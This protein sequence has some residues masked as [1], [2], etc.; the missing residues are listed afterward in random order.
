MA[1]KQT[2]PSAGTIRNV[3]GQDYVSTGSEFIPM[4]TS[5][6]EAPVATPE[7]TM[8]APIVPERS[9]R[10][11]LSSGVDTV[12]EFLPAA[13]AALGSIAGTPGTLLGYAGGQG[14]RELVQRGSEI[15]G[16]VRDIYRNLRDG[17][18]NVRLA[19]LRGAS[20]GVA[21]GTNIIPGGRGARAAVSSLREGNP[22]TAT[23]Q[24]LGAGLDV[25]SVGASGPIRT[26]FANAPGRSTMAALLGLGGAKAGEAV[27]DFAADEMKLTPDQ[28]VLAETLG[29]IPGFAV[30][31]GLVHPKTIALAKDVAASPITQ[32][33]VSGG[34]ALAAGG[35]IPGAIAAAL[36]SSAANKGFKAA[37]DYA[38]VRREKIA[39][40]E[41]MQGIGIAAKREDVANKLASDATL[42]AEARAETAKNT[43]AKTQSDLFKLEQ[44]HKNRL[45][46]EVSQAGTSAEGAAL[47]RSQQVG[48]RFESREYAAKLAKEKA[49]ANAL[50][51][52]RQDALRASREGKT[53]QNRKEG[54]ARADEI[55]AQQERLASEKA[56]TTRGNVL[57][58][59]AAR[60]ARK[61]EITAD[62]AAAQLSKT[63]LSNVE[64]MLKA[65][66]P[67][68]L[69]ATKQVADYHLE[70]A[71][72]M[73]PNFRAALQSKI[74][75]VFETQSA[76][77]AERRAAQDAQMQGLE[78]NDIR[79]T[80][81]SSTVDAN[82]RRQ[83]ITE[84]F[85]KP[86]PVEELIPQQNTPTPGAMSAPTGAAPK[87]S[88][89]VTSDN[90]L[91]KLKEQAD[92]EPVL[93]SLEDSG[94][95]PMAARARELSRKL[96]LSESE[97]TEL[98]GLL[99]RMKLSAR[100]AGVTYPGAGGPANIVN[101][102]V[103]GQTKLNTAG[104]N[105]RR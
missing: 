35:G 96:V 22:Y 100:E 72:G 62:H 36:T 40:D 99:D 75:Q 102:P 38:A 15:P 70:L 43:S 33:L 51:L 39:S 80:R 93:V 103:T 8:D 26:M 81:S 13:G 101:N 97:A 50:E 105:K 7:Q 56:T 42:L 25:A 60:N 34:T 66:T 17:D 84:A 1:Q 54:F 52:E 87:P 37:K 85:G 18:P 29:G 21:E 47:K 9:F 76:T 28:R 41:R 67:D 6:K 94:I 48:D 78:S 77:M 74:D 55:R 88:T 91:E 89:K 71:E 86:A 19:T 49:A 2:F 82:N 32:G 58:D 3:G 30:G 45:E 68:A 61:V 20:E 64:S 95:M 98:A 90:V 83:R 24:A 10:D 79:A 4:P 31:A 65:Q 57:S 92:A 73:E 59:A 5:G 44:A 53:E 16:A 11:V 46:L 69:N 104:R 23:A 27:G 63:H 14:I 12:A